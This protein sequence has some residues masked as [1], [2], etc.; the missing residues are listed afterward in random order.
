MPFGARL[1]RRSGDL[2]GISAE[3]NLSTRLRHGRRRA[4]PPQA[5][6]VD[7]RH[8]HGPLPGREP[9]PDG[10]IRR[11]GPDGTVLP[12]GAERATSAAPEDAS[13][14][15]APFEPRWKNSKEPEP[16]LQARPIPVPRET[17][18]SCA[19]LRF[20]CFSTRIGTRSWKCPVK[21]PAPPTAPWSALRRAGFWAPFSVQPFPA[22]KNRTS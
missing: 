8:V 15:E 2:R 9:D 7:R 19:W 3:R 13:T 11:P 1:R 22:P 14:S 21:A 6:S 16:P 4:F 20:P 17:A 10:R 5:R 18:A 12:L